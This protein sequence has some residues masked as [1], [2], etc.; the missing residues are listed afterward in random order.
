MSKAEEYVAWKLAGSCRSG[1]DN[2]G[3]RAHALKTPVGIWD[4]ALCGREPSGRSAGWSAYPSE[5]VTCPA[6]LKRLER[7][8]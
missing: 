4:K 3:T 2:T 7:L 6:C 5:T 1:S 8:P